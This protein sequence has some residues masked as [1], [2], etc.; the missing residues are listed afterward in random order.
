MQQQRPKHEPIFNAPTSVVA[1]IGILV[2]IHVA[3]LPLSIGLDNWFI[4]LTALIP[5]R[6]TGLAAELPGGV[7]AIFTTPITHMFVHGG[8]A[9]L[10]FNSLWLLIFGS[11][12]ALRVGALRFLSFSLATGLAGATLFTLLNWGEEIPVVG[13]SGAISG[14]L[15]GVMRFL[16]RAFDYG[17]IHILRESPRAVPLMSLSETF[18][19]RRVLALIAIWLLLNLISVFGFDGIDAGG[20]VAWEAHVGGFVA[21]LLCYG[22]FDELR[23]KPPKKPTHL[24]VV[25]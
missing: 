10:I 11:I 5:A 8:A 15:G 21:G 16:F 1:L 20:G 6:I 23:P 4:G 19:D 12:I 17:G 2:A 22:W 25:H 7:A 9:H 24:R 18:S 13:A 3:R 14:L